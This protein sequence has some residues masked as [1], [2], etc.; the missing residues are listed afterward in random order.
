MVKRN[1]A[2]Q[3]FSVPA[4]VYD[5]AEGALEAY[6]HAYDQWL[7]TDPYETPACDRAQAV[8]VVAQRCRELRTAYHSLAAALN[9]GT[10]FA[11]ALQHATTQLH[12]EEERAT[13]LAD[14]LSRVGGES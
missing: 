8:R 13:A 14:S 7:S 6:R 9:R 3:A 1:N 5:A 10:A 11:A 4:D 12:T 2:E